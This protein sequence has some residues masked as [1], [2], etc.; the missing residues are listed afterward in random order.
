MGVLR[1]CLWG[2][3]FKVEGAETAVEHERISPHNW[4]LLFFV[5]ANASNEPERKYSVALRNQP[6]YLG[7]KGS[8]SEVV[9]K[10]AA[11]L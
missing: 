6:L 2:S 7:L 3:L 4:F 11:T 10:R 8:R 5:Y 9:Y 1:F